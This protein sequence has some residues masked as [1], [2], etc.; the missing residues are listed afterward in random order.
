MVPCPEPILASRVRS[1][2]SPSWTIGGPTAPPR[3]WLPPE[4]DAP[5][6][7]LERPADVD[8]TASPAADRLELTPTRAASP[9]VPDGVTAEG[10]AAAGMAVFVARRSAAV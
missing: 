6:I 3:P 4:L 9:P 10:A 5:P 8:G 1:R 7:R 2:L